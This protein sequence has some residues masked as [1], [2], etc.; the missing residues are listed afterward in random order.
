MFAFHACLPCA[1][2]LQKTAEAPTCICTP[3]A[4]VNISKHFSFN[5]F[6]CISGKKWEK[7]EAT[8]HHLMILHFKAGWQCASEGGNT[9]ISSPSFFSGGSP[10]AAIGVCKYLYWITWSIF[11]LLAAFADSIWHGHLKVYLLALSFSGRVTCNHRARP[12]FISQTTCVFSFM[13]SEKIDR[14]NLHH[15]SHLFVAMRI[16]L[17]TSCITFTK[18]IT[19]N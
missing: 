16:I 12:I 1:R 15:V 14:E 11:L 4:T 13:I 3:D 6:V 2:K 17:R 10:I 9:D 5:V 19:S 18:T 8:K 7:V